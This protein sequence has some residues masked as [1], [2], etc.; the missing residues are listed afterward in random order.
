MTRYLPYAVTLGLGSKVMPLRAAGRPHV[1]I[2][3][4]HTKA[5]TYDDLKK[6]HSLGLISIVGRTDEDELKA[7][8]AA[9]PHV[10]TEDPRIYRL[11]GIRSLVLENVP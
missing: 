6:L 7:A 3:T 4:Q 11:R 5:W 8:P 10:E 9:A 1:E 2:H